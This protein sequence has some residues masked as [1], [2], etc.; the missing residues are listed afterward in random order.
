MNTHISVVSGDGVSSS[1]AHVQF[2]FYE[3]GFYVNNECLAEKVI[4]HLTENKLHLQT[5]YLDINI[6]I[7]FTK[8]KKG[9]FEE[10]NKL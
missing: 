6:D 3:K 2:T 1:F 7:Y 9:K 4:S 10:G 8:K 5:I